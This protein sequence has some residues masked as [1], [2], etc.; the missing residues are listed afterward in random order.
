MKLK[1]MCAGILALGAIHCANDASSDAPTVKVDDGIEP[2][3][4]VVGPT[5]CWAEIER[6][7]PA[8]TTQGPGEGRPRRPLTRQPWG[9]FTMRRYGRGDFHPSG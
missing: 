5:H 1:T 7:I 2:M 4:P 6:P 9:C 8:D 3:S